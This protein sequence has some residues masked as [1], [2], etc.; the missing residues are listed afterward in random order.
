VNYL[1]AFSV[2]AVAA[3]ITAPLAASAAAPPQHIRGTIASASAASF[4]VTTMAGP[5]T[6]AIGPKTGVAGATAGSTADIT[7]GTFLGIASVPSAGPNRAL[8]VVVFPNSMRGTGEG[9][10]PWDL[11]A[12]AMHHSTMTNGTV[13][14]PAAHSTMTNATVGTMSG[15]SE[16]RITMNY[17]GGSRTIVVPAGAPVVRVAPG[18]K[19][20]L[21]PGSAVFVIATSTAKPTALFVIVGVNGTKPPM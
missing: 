12:G 1:H 17:K 14:M 9:D 8:E 4:T 3:A 10:Y 6:V 5:V 21:V 18:S 7:P 20:L 16:K 13:A 15:S 11:S 2:A 19:K